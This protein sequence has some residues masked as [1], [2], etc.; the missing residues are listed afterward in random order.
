MRRPVP[1]NQ[2]LHGNVPDNCNVVLLL[3]D[4]LNDLDFPDNSA[5]VK[6]I[7]VLGANISRLKNHCH[8]AGIPVIYVNDNYG[9][10]RSDRNAVITPSSRFAGVSLG[11]KDHP[12]ATDYVILKPKHS[13]FYATPLDITAFIPKSDDSNIGGTYY[14]RAHLNQRERNIRAGLGALRCFRL[15]RGAGQT[16]AS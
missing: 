10:W 15:R 13:I 9:K 7:P 14:K 3:V 1:K 2:D 5:L 8:N 6:T 12:R 11:R 4:V 16:K